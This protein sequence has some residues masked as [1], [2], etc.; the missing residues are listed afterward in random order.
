MF[1]QFDPIMYCEVYCFVMSA[2]IPSDDYDPWSGAIDDI[3][4]K[5]EESDQSSVELG[6]TRVDNGEDES[7]AL[8]TVY[9]GTAFFEV[10]MISIQAGLERFVRISYPSKLTD[11]EPQEIYPSVARVMSATYP[12]TDD[13]QTP[14]ANLVDTDNDHR[15]YDLSDHFDGVLHDQA[16]LDPDIYIAE[17]YLEFLDNEMSEDFS[18]SGE[19]YYIHGFVKDDEG[20]E[21]SLRIT[22]NKASN[23]LYEE[24]LSE[25]LIRNASNLVRDSVTQDEIEDFKE[26]MKY[27]CDLNFPSHDTED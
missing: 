9:V 18:G 19:P 24:L 6:V 1:L 3:F 22:H 25:L 5:E 16:L 8:Y 23:H 17:Y 20:I 13:W 14:L 10:S 26:K 4:R 2:E 27:I 11:F 12:D 7:Q 21:E 15:G